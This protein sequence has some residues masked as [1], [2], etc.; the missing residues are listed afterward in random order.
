MVYSTRTEQFGYQDS[1]LDGYRDRN[2]AAA[3]HV[4]VCERPSRVLLF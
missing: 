4:I 2:C 3:A 1:R